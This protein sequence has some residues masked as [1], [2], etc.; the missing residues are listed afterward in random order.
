MSLYHVV[1]L[2]HECFICYSCNSTACDVQHAVFIYS[3]SMFV[4]FTRRQMCTWRGVKTR[5]TG[6]DGRKGRMLLLPGH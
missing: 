2:S 6:Q 4:L 1:S 5:R 3:S